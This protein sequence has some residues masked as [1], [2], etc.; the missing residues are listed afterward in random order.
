M[1]PKRLSTAGLSAGLRMPLGIQACMSAQLASVAHCPLHGVIS[2][3]V[4]CRDAVQLLLQEV[5]WDEGSREHRRAERAAIMAQYEEIGDLQREPLF[6]AETALK[7][8]HRATWLPSC[9]GACAVHIV[10]CCFCSSQ[11]PLLWHEHLTKTSRGI[12]FAYRL[13]SA[14]PS[15]IP[16]VVPVVSI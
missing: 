14:D 16:L 3:T 9:L 1:P 8:P 13:L 10:P 2:A 7:V 15:G 4:P 6:C 5:A 12:A 11:S